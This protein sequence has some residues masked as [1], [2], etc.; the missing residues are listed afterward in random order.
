MGR[1]G[2]IVI[3]VTKR[4][5][6]RVLPPLERFMSEVPQGFAVFRMAAER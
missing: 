3:A 6:S 5:F 4:R 1:S 2:M